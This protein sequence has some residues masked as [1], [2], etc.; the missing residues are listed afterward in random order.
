MKGWSHLTYVLAGLLLGFLVATLVMRVRVK[1]IAEAFANAQ[2]DSIVRIQVDPGSWQ[3]I[4]LILG[5]LDK[6]YVDQ[7]DREEVTKGAVDGALYALD[8]HSMYFPPEDLKASEEDIKG[9][10]DG[11]GIQFNVPQDTAIVLEVIS[12]GP[13]E[14]IGLSIGDRILKVDDRVI[15]GVK[16][17]QD[18]IV[19]LIKGPSGTKVR[20]TVLRDGE[21]IPFDITRG[22]IPVHAVDAAFMLDMETGYIRL[23]TFSLNVYNEFRHAVSTLLDDGMKRLVIDL[24]SNTGGLLDQALAIADEFLRD[25]EMIVYTEGLHSKREDHRASG[26][27][28]LQSLPVSVLIDDGSASASEILAGAIQDNDRGVIIGRRSFGKGLVQEPFYFTDGSGIRITVARFYTPSGRC[29]QKPYSEYE[30]GYDLYNRYIDGELF[31]AE[32]IKTDSTD[33]HE[34]VGGRKVYGGGGI[35]PDVFVPMDT[36]SATPFHIGVNKKATMTRF[37]SDFFDRHAARLREID[38]YEDLDSFFRS[39]DLSSAFLRYAADKDG[40]R[41]GPG[42]WEQ[43]SV[44]IIPQLR[45]LV[46]RYSRLGQNAFYKYYAEIDDVIKTA[47]ETSFEVVP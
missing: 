3:K 9:N 23:N 18:S 12:G 2:N 25:G 11:I 6:H 41:P 10:F 20:I 21:I 28:T 14:K 26:A 38:S 17:P 8:P 44:Y 29:I 37:A 15:A 42:E 35:I 5:L 13:S 27:G 24:R 46:G 4:N 43:S 7:I 47:L 1:R 39:V 34:T 22:R 16:M 33:V 31:S 32:A 36:T 19:R 40:L 30:D 45:A